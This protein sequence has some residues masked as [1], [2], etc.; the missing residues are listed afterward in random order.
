MNI[1]YKTLIR[2]VI[3]SKK[4]I[5]GQCYC[6][7]CKFEFEGDAL[8]RIICHCNV[9]QKYNRGEYAD[10]TVFKVSNVK[11]ISPENNIFK[12]HSKPKM[13][14]RGQCLKCY[15]PTIEN[16][17]AIPHSNIVI[18]PN[19]NLSREY[20]EVQPAAHICYTTRQSD[21]DD[22]IRKYHGLLSSQ[23]A[24]TKI[25]CKSYFFGA[26]KRQNEGI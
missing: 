24:F 9:C 11:F 13:V 14:A 12:Y 25:L 1:Q 18:V 23:I 26:V 20:K 5:K 22:D 19:D 16:F 7:H 4:I 3:V 6:G 10:N 15:M 8:F 17:T 2:C 21:V